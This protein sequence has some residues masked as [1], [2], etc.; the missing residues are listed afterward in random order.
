MHLHSAAEGILD[1]CCFAEIASFYYSV[2]ATG[3]WTSYSIPK[4]FLNSILWLISMEEMPPTGVAVL[5]S[6]ISTTTT[7]I[8]PPRTWDPAPVLNKYPRRGMTSIASFMVVPV[9]DH[10]PLTLTVI[11]A[12]ALFQNSISSTT[13]TLKVISSSPLQTSKTS[14]KSQLFHFLPHLQS[15][16]TVLTRAPLWR[17]LT[18][19]SK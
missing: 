17:L 8:S 6:H 4:A 19:S 2:Y 1:R 15:G 11:S 16:F 5:N 7:H 10:I 12:I 9:L 14:L 3:A 13:Q 18:S